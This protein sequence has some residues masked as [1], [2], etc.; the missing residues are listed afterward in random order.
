MLP[1]A[2]S[3]FLRLKIF[4]GGS[5]RVCA[6]TKREALK[7]RERTILRETTDCTRHYSFGCLFSY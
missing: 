5:G 6:N 1:G 3:D 4:R 2:S 7:L